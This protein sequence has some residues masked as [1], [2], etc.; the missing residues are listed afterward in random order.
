MV[1]SKTMKNCVSKTQPGYCEICGKKML[2]VDSCEV[3][4][5]EIGG[6]IYDRIRSTAEN[7]HDCGCKA[8]GYHHAGCDMETCPECGG[9][10]I[11]CSHYYE[12]KE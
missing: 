1:K 12:G 11:S 10:L 8:G 7:C 2:D 9:Q 3:T 5:V 4:K 6:K